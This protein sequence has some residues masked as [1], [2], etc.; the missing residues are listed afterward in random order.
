M[1]GMM[2]ATIFVV[3]LAMAALYAKHGLRSVHIYIATAAG[4]SF[5][6]LLGSALMGLVFLSSG[7]GHDE[8]VA[9][10]DENERRR[11]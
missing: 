11:R 5:T 7:T 3:V 10:P 1:R 4:I 8:A 2:L 9:E 6:M